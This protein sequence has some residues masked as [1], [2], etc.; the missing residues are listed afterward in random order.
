MQELV[1]VVF[2]GIAGVMLAIQF[3]SRKPEYGMYMGLAVGILV[4]GYALRQVAAVTAQLSK[5]QSYLGGAESYLAI[6]LKVIGITYICEFGADIC[7]DAGYQTVAGQIEVLG[8][9]SVMFAG[10]P[11]LFAVIEQIQSFL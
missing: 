9:L 5:L 7:K 8:K 6:L 11:V 10:L 3:K 2:L 4:F 1:R